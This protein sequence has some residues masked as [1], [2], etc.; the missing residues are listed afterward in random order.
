M[1]VETV[2]VDHPLVL[3][4]LAVIRDVE[5]PNAL[6]RQNLERIGTLLIAEATQTLPTVSGTV[7]TPL[8]TAA[9]ERIAVQP[10]IVPILRA[11]L[12]FLR[13]AQEL[14]PD[15][16][17]GFIG[18]ARNEETHQPE[19]YVNKLPD[20]IASRPVI[21]VDPMLATGGSLIHTLRLL[22]ERGASQPLTV[23]VALAAPEGIAAL[24][25]SGIDVTLFTAVIDERLN[26]S[27]YIVPGLGD[28]GDRQF[29]APA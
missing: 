27:A 22:I 18:I 19:P 8:T 10:V 23:I 11:G 12:G 15:A 25:A 24:E 29:G 1:T 26:D 21:V 5:T 20:N 4:S 6:F 17:I 2:V 7:E 9:T 3:D 16:D 14:L 28:A 13:P